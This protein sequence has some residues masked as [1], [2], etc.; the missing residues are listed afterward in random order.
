MD[1]DRLPQWVKDDFPPGP[2][3][4]HRL[5]LLSSLGR[6]QLHSGPR[7]PGRPDHLHQLHLERPRRPGRPRHGSGLAERPAHRRLPPRVRTPG[8][9]QR[10]QSSPTVRP[11]GPGPALRIRN[12][13]RRPLPG[14]AGK[15]SMPCA[16]STPKRRC[17]AGRT[18]PPTP[19]WTAILATPPLPST[20][21]ASTRTPEPEPWKYP[22][23]L[24]TSPGT[25]TS[26]WTVR[27]A[28]PSSGPTA[29]RPIPRPSWSTRNGKWPWSGPPTSNWPVGS[30]PAATSSSAMR[31]APA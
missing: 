28:T 26:D 6:V 13:P 18:A 16:V 3:S 31:S 17:R 24:R 11:A 25:S 21:A 2:P 1:Y 7:P 10:P 15:S 5:V 29:C 20:S 4:K 14:L 19:T 30:P 27:S 23:P 8:N 12:R 22:L 9:L